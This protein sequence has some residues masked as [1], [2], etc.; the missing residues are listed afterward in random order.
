MP[1]A[2]SPMLSSASGRVSSPWPRILVSGGVRPRSAS[3][4]PSRR[5]L[6]AAG[7]EDVDGFG[8]GVLDALDEGGE[9]RVGDRRLVGADDLAAGLVEA[10][11]EGLLGVMA[12]AVVGDQRV[13][14]LD[15]AVSK[16]HLPKG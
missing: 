1:L 8:V 15:A 7:D 5:R 9:V 10:L 12:G 14:L 16:A 6:R 2:V 13:G 4:L 3:A 11:G